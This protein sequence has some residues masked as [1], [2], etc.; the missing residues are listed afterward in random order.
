M[1]LNHNKEYNKDIRA[2][3]KKVFAHA[4]SLSAISDL[5]RACPVCGSVDNSFYA[6]NDYFDYVKCKDCSLL[7]QNPTINPGKIN[8]GFKG[9]DEILMEYFKIIMKYKTG[10]PGKPDPK[11]DAKLSDIYARKQ[12]GRL[13]DVGCSVGD[14]LHKA[15]Y[16]YEVEGVEMNPLTSAIAKKHFTVYQN[17]LS[18]LNLSQ[19]YDIITL[20]QILYGVPSPVDL[21]RDIHRI[22][23]NDGVLYVNTPNSD[24]HAMD[25]YKGKANHLYGYTTQN[26]FNEKSLK[27]LADSTGFEVK[28]FRTEWL[29]IYITDIL[30]LQGDQNEFIHKRN[31]HVEGYEEKIEMEDEM[32]RKMKLNLGSKGNY[33]VAILEKK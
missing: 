15:S 5:K 23:K 3:L 16:F 25:F 4:Q 19:S 26:V 32:Q 2:W 1:S 31:C 8:Q 13:L 12:K 10:I 17:Y 9:E 21:L 11:T 27:K 6:N 18:E 29:D 33:I 7:F 20:N 14:F 24:S 30:A 22:L 28:S